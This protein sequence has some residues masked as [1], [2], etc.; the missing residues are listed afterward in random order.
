MVVR[1]VAV[2][3]P[4]Q[5]VT[6]RVGNALVGQPLLIQAVSTPSEQGPTMC[7]CS[8]LPAKSVVTGFFF[9]VDLLCAECFRNLVPLASRAMHVVRQAHLS[10]QYVCSTSAGDQSRER[11]RVPPIDKQNCRV[12]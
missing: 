5:F 4:R 8:E 3:G 11:T 12:L 7:L 10:I 9:V 2:S 6:Q 1:K